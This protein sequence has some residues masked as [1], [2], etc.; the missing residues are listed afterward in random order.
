[1]YWAVFAAALSSAAVAAEPQTVVQ[2][3][4]T[5][6]VRMTVEAETEAVLKVLA[7]TDGVYSTLNTDI[8]RT[9]SEKRGS[10]EEVRRETRGVFRP[11][12]FRSLR[13][14]SKDGFT[15]TLLDSD[16]ITTYQTSWELTKTATGTAIVYKVHTELRPVFPRPLVLQGTLAGAKETVINLARVLLKPKARE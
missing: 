8:Y 9:V 12:K 1:M 11:F 3:D 4:G 10:C 6:E 16:D 7:D 13:C 14:P 5:V 2:S 15:E